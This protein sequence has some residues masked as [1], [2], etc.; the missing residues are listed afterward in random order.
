MNYPGIIKLPLTC[1][2]LNGYLID[3]S[4]L[5][6]SKVTQKVYG[7]EKGNAALF[8]QVD[9]LIGKYSYEEIVEQFPEVDDD[10]LKE[11]CD[12]ASCK[13]TNNH[14][15]YE[16]DLGFGFGIFVEDDLPRI[17]YQVDN[18]VF[19]F[20][21]P[22]DALFKRLH[23]VYEHLHVDKP[24]AK[25]IVSVDFIKSGDLWNIKYNNTI[26]KVLT[27]EIGIANYLQVR[28]LKRT[29]QAQP[30][31]ISLHAAS[32]EKNGK[33]IIMPAGPHSGKTTLTA[34]LLHHGYK[35][36][37]DESTSMDNDGYVRP[38]PFCMNIKEGSWDVLSETYPH[39]SEL[40]VHRRPSGL[41]I[42]FLAPVNMYKG[43]QK[44]SHII[45]PKYTPGAKTSLTPI[46]AK[47]ALYKINKAYYQVQHDM[48]E[49]K[50]ELI[51]KNLISLPKY[52]LVYSKLD[53][54][55]KAID[56]LLEE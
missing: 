19:A 49:N 20:H 11:M 39:L 29:Y 40:D 4:L 44:G 28:L 54:A 12:L 47:E 53:E 7:F 8:L 33:V 18:I 34:T 17:F 16:K 27:P 3:E 30:Y 21:Y 42:R 14:P 50:F 32:L 46:S 9:E 2:S 45:F 1:N 13:E 26:A 55:I 5:I 23:P 31:L 25:T 15:E 41:G 36:F 35:S 52:T 22:N 38:L 6:H 43:R 10:L 24:D 51:L 56:G 37:N 48:D